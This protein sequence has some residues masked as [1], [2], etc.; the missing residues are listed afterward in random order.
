MYNQ[1]GLTKLLLQGLTVALARELGGD[2][3]TVNA[4]APGP[5]ATPATTDRYPIEPFL[6]SMPIKRMGR[7]EDLAAMLAFLVSD[8]AEWVTG[9][10]IHVNGG[11]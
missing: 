9:Q 7:S 5:I 6:E 4:I 3:I 11:F 10:T 1:Y 8:A 2:G